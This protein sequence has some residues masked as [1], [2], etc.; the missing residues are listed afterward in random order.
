[1][2]LPKCYVR[3]AD[4]CYQYTNDLRLQVIFYVDF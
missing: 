3:T 2:S 1:M 4:I